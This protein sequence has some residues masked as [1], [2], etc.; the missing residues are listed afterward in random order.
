MHESNNKRNDKAQGN[1]AYIIMKS[2]D[3]LYRTYKVV[4][5]E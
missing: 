5:I 3:P 2:N 1:I 4:H